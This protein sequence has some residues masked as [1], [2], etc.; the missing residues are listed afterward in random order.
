MSTYVWAGGPV[1]DDASMRRRPAEAK[2]AF[3]DDMAYVNPSP[4]APAR[5]RL[6]RRCLIE[7]TSSDQTA[8]RSGYNAR[9]ASAARDIRRDGKSPS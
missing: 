9:C 1:A 7:E 8:S 3:A 6:A 4:P 5:R 2:Q